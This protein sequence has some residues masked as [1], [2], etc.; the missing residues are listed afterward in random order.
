MDE[1]NSEI[2]EYLKEERVSFGK[3]PTRK[4]WRAINRD[5]SL[6]HSRSAKDETFE[7]RHVQFFAK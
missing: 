4:V 5:N 7:S 1:K 3:N 2:A 6:I